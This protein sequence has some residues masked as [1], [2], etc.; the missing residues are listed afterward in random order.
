MCTK[1]IANLLTLFH[2]F[3][4]LPRISTLLENLICRIRFSNIKFEWDSAKQL[5]LV[6]EGYDSHYF[7]FSARGFQLFRNGI[8]KRAEFLFNSYLLSNITFERNDVIIDCGANWGDL[9]IKFRELGI[10]NY[11]AFE[12]NDLTYKVLKLNAESAT[13]L[14]IGLG[15]RSEVANFYV[16]NSDASSSFVQPSFFSYQ[17]KIQI[18]T[19]DEWSESMRIQTVKL[20]K[21][22][23]EGFELEI[24]KGTENLLSRIHYIALDGGP[25]RGIDQK[26]TFAECSNYLYKQGF[27]MVEVYFPWYRGLFKNSLFA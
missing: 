11:F 14:N 5:M 24:L 16:D 1:V 7:Q 12:P 19:L 18:H 27:E 17:K 13:C 22:D 23:G 4:K 21:V 9:Y 6:S 10:L 8:H 2:N 3:N 26:S 15:N 20:L 25:E